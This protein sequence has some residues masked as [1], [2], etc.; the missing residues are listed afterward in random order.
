MSFYDQRTLEEYILECPH[1]NMLY[2]MLLAF[3]SW[4][5]VLRTKRSFR[6]KRLQAHMDVNN[7]DPLTVLN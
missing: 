4:K 2:E 3:R 1:K 7:T 5:N 6:K